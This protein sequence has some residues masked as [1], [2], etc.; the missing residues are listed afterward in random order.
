[1]CFQ[2]RTSI[3]S[4][5]DL[6]IVW[7]EFLIFGLKFGNKIKAINTHKLAAMVFIYITVHVQEKLIKCCH[8]DELHVRNQSISFISKLHL[9]FV[10]IFHSFKHFSQ[11]PFCVPFFF[12]I[13]NINFVLILLVTRCCMSRFW[14]SLYFQIR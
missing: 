8:K 12:V 6:S 2:N 5:I 7:H 11:P 10:Y 3:L 4:P 9:S 13:Y 14:Y 1:M